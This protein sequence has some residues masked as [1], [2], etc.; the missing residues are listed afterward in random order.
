MLNNSSYLFLFIRTLWDPGL[1]L[2]WFLLDLGTS[3]WEFGCLGFKNVYF[4][5][6]VS[7]FHCHMSFGSESN[8]VKHQN[9]WFAVK[10]AQFVLS[11]IVGFYEFR[12]QSVDV[13]WWPWG[14]SSGLMVQSR[15]ASNSL[16][17]MDIL[18]V[19]L[20]QV[21]H[22]CGGNWLCETKRLHGGARMAAL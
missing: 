20:V 16:I 12:G 10:C 22:T 8:G 17:L 1:D 19:A 11:Q 3:F 5:L 21:M 9:Q 14:H 18:E 2:F 6:L 13:S 15:Q 4:V 7:R